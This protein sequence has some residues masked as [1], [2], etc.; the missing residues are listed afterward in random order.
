MQA[1]LSWIWR[2]YGWKA[3][4]CM[5]LASVNAGAIYVA[6]GPTG[7]SGRPGVLTVTSCSFITGTD[8]L[9]DGNY[10]PDHGHYRDPLF[11]HR[12]C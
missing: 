6:G 10:R 1:R 12:R 4:A 11:R 5:V 7:P 2:T 3:V 8:Y 9:C